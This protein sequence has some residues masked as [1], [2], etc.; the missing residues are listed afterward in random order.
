MVKL[1]IVESS[2]A[3]PPAP[4][5][6]VLAA[7]IA[8]FERIAAKPILIVPPLLLDLFLWLGPRLTISGLLM[9]TAAQIGQLAGSD[10]VL[11]QQAEPLRQGLES[12]TTRFNL[13]SALNTFPIGLPSLIAG[14][15]PEGNPLGLAAPLD[16]SQPGLI[17]GIWLALTLAGVALGALYHRWLAHLTFPGAPIA[18]WAPIWGR[19]L[20]LT[21]A[22]YIGLIGWMSVTALVATLV[23]LLIPLLGAGIVFIG[24]SLLAWLGMYLVFTPHGIVRFR[25]GLG[26]A[27]SESIQIVRW[28]TLSVI[29]YVTLALIV[30]WLGN[31]VWNLGADQSW[32][33]VLGIIGHALVTAVLLAGSYILYQNRRG[34]M[35]TLRQAILERTGSEQMPGDHGGTEEG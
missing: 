17:V 19:M 11:Q 32:Y 25:L 27:M 9:S 13:F 6:G 15:L 33:L 26:K 28:N 8:G 18:R 31:L 21:A 30:T 7:L 34:W 12:L 4:P 23:G 3:R 14:R 22:V 20:M 10:S 2:A 35:I 5:I 29:G 1:K 16:I 24:A